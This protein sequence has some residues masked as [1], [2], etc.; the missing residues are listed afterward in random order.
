MPVKGNSMVSKIGSHPNYGLSLA[1]IFSPIV[2]NSLINYGY[3]IYLK[4]V[5]ESSGV[6]YDDNI[7][8]ALGEFFDHIY[9]IMATSHRT[10]Y[11]YKNA[12]ANKIL[13]GK[14][15]INTACML[16]EFRVG[17]CKADIVVLNKTSTVYE[18]KSEFDSFDRIESQVKSYSQVFDLIYIITSHNQLLKL[19][20]ILPRKIGLMEL[21]DAYTIKTV[22]EATSLKNQVSPEIIFDSLRKP[23]Y[24]DIIKTVYGYV[25]DVP[26]TRIYKECRNLFIKLTPEIAHDQMLRVLRRRSNN[27]LLTRLIDRIPTSLRAYVLSTTLS[28]SQAVKLEQL[29]RIN[30]SATLVTP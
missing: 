1:R 19:E 25:P 30:L 29:M 8:M 7:D 28:S 18:I 27:T 11:I 23:E 2:I 12:I 22:R 14:H 26:N 24:L 13:L 10:E 6:L 9:K 5:L 3:S 21:T 16:N 20:M 17:T 15:S 4:D